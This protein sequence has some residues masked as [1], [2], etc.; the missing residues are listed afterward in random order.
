MSMT[1]TLKIFSEKFVKKISKRPIPNHVAIIMDGNR[2]WGKIN[3]QDKSSQLSCH[4][5]GAE[6]V[7]NLI[8]AAIELQ[9]STLTLF[10]FSTENFSRD[11]HEVTELFLLFADYLSEQYSFMKEHNVRLRFI[12]DL[13]KLPPFLLEKML[14]TEEKLQQCSSIDLVLAINY[15]SKNE[16]L[17]AF[18]KIHNDLLTQKIHYHDLSEPL[19]ESY[20]DTSDISE[21][22]LLIRTAGEMRISNFLLWQIAYTEFYVTK[23]LWPDFTP[24][25]LVK[26]IRAYQ[27]R[28]RRGGK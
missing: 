9:I 25:D 15:G 5:H 28:E 6:V 20:L 21:P 10:A 3:L 8:L 23:T 27:K 11:E 2:R 19:I 26:A 18:K 17:R 7:P 14:E 1:T 24:N 4:K 13:T 12:G 22:D 16:I